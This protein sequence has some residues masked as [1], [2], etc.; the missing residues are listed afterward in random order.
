MFGRGVLFGKGILPGPGERGLLDALSLGEPE[1]IGFTFEWYRYSIVSYCWIIMISVPY[2]WNFKLLIK[3]RATVRPAPC[4]PKTRDYKSPR[5]SLTSLILRIDCVTMWEFEHDR[6]IGWRQA[7]WANF[8][9]RVLQWTSLAFSTR[10]DWALL[11]K[12]FGATNSGTANSE[13][14]AGR[15]APRQCPSIESKRMT[16]RVSWGFLVWGPG[17]FLLI[18]CHSG[19]YFRRRAL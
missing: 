10:L 1:E 2:T 18:S 9:R 11:V 7:N 17:T 13:A 12:L 16:V 3:R 6:F 8:R 5:A 14:L 19:S 4:C 15:W